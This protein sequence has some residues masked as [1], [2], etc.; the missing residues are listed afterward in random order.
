MQNPSW[1]MTGESDCLLCPMRQLSIFAGLTIEDLSHLGMVVEDIHLPAGATLYRQGENARYAF[2][3]RSGAMK[4]SVHRRHQDENRIVRLLRYGDLLGFEGLNQARLHYQ[5][6]ATALDASDLCLLDLTALNRLSEDRPKVR[7]ALI[8]RWQSALEEAE[9]Q[10]V[11]I[12]AGKA[13]AC[14][15]AFLCHWCRVFPDGAWVPFPIERKELAD[16]LGFSAA[17][18]SRV[19]ADF[20]RNGY[21]KESGKRINIQYIPLRRIAG[22]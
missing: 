11:E 10:L 15:A 14:V 17:H 2:T 3:L 18:V 5:H 9:F 21:V 4:L 22:A 16:Y 1:E 8:G 12:G 7:Q 6:T 13:E 19:M 20:K